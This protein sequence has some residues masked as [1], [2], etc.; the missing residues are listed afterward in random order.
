MK[1]PVFAYF[2]IISSLIPVAVGIKRFRLLRKDGLAMFIFLSISACLTLGQFLLAKMNKNNL[3]VGHLWS[4]SETCAMLIFYSRWSQ[5]PFFR[6]ILPWVTFSFFIFLLYVMFKVESFSENS[7]IAG[8]I[9]RLILSIV[10]PLIL[11][12]LALSSEKNILREWRFWIVTF[13]FFFIIEHIPTH[14]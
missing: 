14:C 6:I 11:I 10:S 3:W 13:T 7:I 8:P 4:A 12:G 2:A 9:S 1:I 5:R